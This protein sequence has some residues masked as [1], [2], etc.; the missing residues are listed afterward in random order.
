[1]VL[2]ELYRSGSMRTSELL[3]FL[4]KSKVEGF[5][6]DPQKMTREERFP[7]LMRLNRRIIEKLEEA[8]YIEKKRKGRENEIEITQSGRYV[9]CISGLI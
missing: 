5:D 1:M 3:F 9:A 6:Q 2:V 8:G 7:L 4:Y